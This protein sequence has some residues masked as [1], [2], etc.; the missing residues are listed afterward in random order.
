LQ[1][2]AL[3]ALR[4]LIGWHFLYEGLAKMLNPYW[5]SAGYL[6]QSD[7]WFGGLFLKIAANPTV[8]TAVDYLNIWGLTLIGLGLLFGAFTRVATIAGIALLAMYYLA[9]PP[10]VGLTYAMPAEGSYLIVNKVL[11]ELAALVV[12][13][14][15]RT[16]RMLG[17]D[18]LLLMR[19]SDKLAAA[20]A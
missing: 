3:V 2:G 5:T 9:T 11:I 13:L 19:R 17:V 1:Q 8:L 4:M 16:E 20:S 12:L 10:F 6:A 18:R 15:F 7:W 14:A